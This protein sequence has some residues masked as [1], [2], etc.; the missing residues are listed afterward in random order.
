MQKGYAKYEEKDIVKHWG[1]KENGSWFVDS[2]GI[3]IAF[4]CPRVANVQKDII[5]A[6]YAENNDEGVVTVE[7]I[8]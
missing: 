2:D 7:E 1:L 6:L 3:L 5:D 8:K 4:T